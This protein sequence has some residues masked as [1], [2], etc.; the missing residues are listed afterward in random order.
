MRR[1]GPYLERVMLTWAIFQPWRGGVTS[2][3]W[4]PGPPPLCK[5]A[6]RRVTFE[7]LKYLMEEVC[8]LR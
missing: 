8:E 3:T 1:T 7:N 4:G 5:R 6:L 2:S